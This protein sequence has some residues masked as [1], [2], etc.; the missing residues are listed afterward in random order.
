L[1]ASWGE[2]GIINAEK[3]KDKMRSLGINS[4]LQQF[5]A[6]CLIIYIV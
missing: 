4:L 3:K 2:A 5:T 6:S 1:P